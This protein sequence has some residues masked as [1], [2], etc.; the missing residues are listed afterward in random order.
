MQTKHTT[1]YRQLQSMGLKL[2]P[3]RAY[4]LR[5]LRRVRRLEFYRVSFGLVPNYLSK[6]VGE[7]KATDAELGRI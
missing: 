5:D 7:A 1:I 3:L 4:T 6:A 2:C